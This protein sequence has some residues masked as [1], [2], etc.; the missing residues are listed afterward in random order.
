MPEQRKCGVCHFFLH[1]IG[2][3]CNVIWDIGKRDPDHSS[4]LKMLSFGEMIA[5][6]DLADPEIIVL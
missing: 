4:A 3:H 6:I 5:K 2:C 1:K